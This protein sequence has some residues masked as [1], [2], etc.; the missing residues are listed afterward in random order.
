MSRFADL[1]LQPSLRDK[2]SLGNLIR[3]AS[4]LNYTLLGISLPS[5]IKQSEKDVLRKTCAEHGVDFTPRIDLHPKS[6][7]ELLRSLRRLRRKFEV[8]SVDCS[9]KAVARQAA[10]DHR[11]DILFVT[12]ES[13]SMRFF[14]KAEA[15]LALQGVAALE[16]N[17]RS[18]LGLT[19]FSRA[20]LL[21][22]LRR[23]VEIAEKHRIPT[24]LSSNAQVTTQIR[25]PHD[26]ASLAALFGMKESAALKGISQ[27]PLA[28]VNRNREKLSSDYV[29]CGVRVVRRI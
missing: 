15:R 11:V 17:M 1:H 8:V 23:E 27:M 25:G 22:Y 5:N 20:R 9:S 26:L 19:R 24:V 18:L 7:R 4:E 29:A 28:I 12:R 3:K 2:K 13:L 16:V 14:D 6:A 10:K 21:S